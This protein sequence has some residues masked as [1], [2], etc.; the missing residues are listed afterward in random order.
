MPSPDFNGRS[1]GSVI[2]FAFAAYC[3]IGQSA[4]F[5]L[6]GD[7][8]GGGH[9][10]YVNAQGSDA[11]A[12]GLVPLGLG[13][14]NIAAGIRGRGRIAVFWWGAAVLGAAFLYG[15]VQVVLRVRA[16]FFSQPG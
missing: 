9:P 5:T 8:N 4:V 10:I 16:D 12:I 11:I 2:L 13:I 6:G 15:L 1:V 14:V 3:L 7:D